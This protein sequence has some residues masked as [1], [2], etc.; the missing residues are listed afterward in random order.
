MTNGVGPPAPSA[1]AV[2]AIVLPSVKTRCGHRRLP[3]DQAYREVW[4]SVSSAVNLALLGT[5]AGTAQQGV[6]QRRVAEIRHADAWITRPT[7]YGNWMAGA[8]AASV[9]GL[10]HRGATPRIR[11]EVSSPELVWWPL[12]PFSRSS[13]RRPG[14]DSARPP[15]AEWIFQ[16][17]RAPVKVQSSPPSIFPPVTARC[18][19]RRKPPRRP[20]RSHHS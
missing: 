6:G 4:Y 1:C 2:N 9:V 17:V 18:L 8:R 13:W 20:R 7:R 14:G 15:V 10:H 5:G 16:T 19:C 11:P 3:P 12:H